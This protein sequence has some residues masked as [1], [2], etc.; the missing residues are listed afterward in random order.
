MAFTT[1]FINIY[2]FI[3]MMIT[4]YPQTMMEL[5]DFPKLSSQKRAGYI[6]Y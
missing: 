5:N 1:D 4:K 3:Y 2:T 6:L